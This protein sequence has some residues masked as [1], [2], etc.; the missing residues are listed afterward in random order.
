MYDIVCVAKL[1]QT[2]GTMACGVKIG[3]LDKAPVTFQHAVLRNMLGIL[4]HLCCIFFHVGTI[5]HG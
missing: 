2:L 5:L 3:A 1:G 4:T